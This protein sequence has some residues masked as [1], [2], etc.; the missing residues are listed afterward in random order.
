MSDKILYCSFCG[1]P[2]NLV[3][4]LIVGPDLNICDE[5]VSSCYEIISEESQLKSTTTSHVKKVQKQEPI[6]DA[7]VEDVS[8][9]FKTL[10]KPKAIFKSLEAYIIGQQHAKKVCSVAVYNHYKRLFC[11]SDDYVDVELKKSNVLLVGPTGTGKTLFAQTLAKML[12][13]P[14]TIA[15]AT[16]LTEA[17]YVGEDVESCLHRLLQSCDFDTKRA[18]RGIVYID[19]IDKISRKSENPSIT[20]DVSGEGVQQALL[21]MLEGTIVNVPMKGGRKHPQ[22]ES[23]PLNT[24][25]IL[26]IC[27]GA[28]QGIERTVETRLNSHKYGFVKQKDEAKLKDKNIYRFIQHE[29]LIKYG[30][31]PELIGRLPV[32]AP[33]HELDEEALV[34]IMREPKNALVKQYQK[35]FKMD[36]VDLSFDKEA[37]VIIAKIAVEKKV[38]ARALTSIFEDIMLEYMF[39]CESGTPSVKIT[40]DTV[41]AYVK[42]NLSDELY[43]KLFPLPGTKTTKKVRGSKKD[44]AA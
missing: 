15:D 3:K 29:D 44:K 23:I 42:E 17:G 21:K 9:D 13:V 6:P 8:L 33:L 22:Q 39:E 19:E 38:G 14:F 18:E 7:K 2:Q 41:Q 31:I 37:C 35:L 10:P 40:S 24:A 4:K 1:K 34:R 30:I 5:C 20:R 16:T 27:G 25:N 32:I 28:F 26:F 11:K 12:D 43:D 36:S